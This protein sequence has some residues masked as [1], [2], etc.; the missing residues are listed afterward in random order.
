MSR[1]LA[2]RQAPL[3]LAGRLVGGFGAV[4]EI[5]VLAVLH[6]RENRPLRRAV[7]FQLVGAAHPGHVLAPCQQLAAEL[8]RRWRVPPALD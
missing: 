7:A 3:P 5:A 2:A 1:R 6:P 8:L 4:R